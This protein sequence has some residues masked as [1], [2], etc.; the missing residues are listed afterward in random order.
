M[1]IRSC[2]GYQHALYYPI[3]RGNQ[4]GL[5]SFWWAS[6]SKDVRAT[7]YSQKP[8]FTRSFVEYLFAIYGKVTNDKTNAG[9]KTFIIKL[10]IIYVN[11]F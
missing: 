11:I 7:Q 9:V 2:K 6:E 3:I 5:V 4:S 1:A 8:L 10:L